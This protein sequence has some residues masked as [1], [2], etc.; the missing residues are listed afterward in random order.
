MSSYKCLVSI[1][2]IAY[3]HDKYISQALEGF[4][5]QKTNFAFEVIV[6]DDAS[7]DETVDIIRGYVDKYPDIIKP[8]FQTENQYSKGIKVSS[9]YVWP[10]ARGRYIALCEG[11][12]YWTDLYKLQKQVDFLEANEDFALCFHKVKVLMQ[13]GS[14]VD[15]FITKVPR[16]VTT[17][18]DLAKRGNYIHTPSVVLRNDFTIP[19]WFLNCPIGDYPLYLIAA[20]QG[21]IKYL[22]DTMAVYRNGVGIHS[23]ASS[24]GRAINLFKTYDAIICNYSDKQISK[25]ISN[26][27][28]RI[29]FSL[30]SK[31]LYDQKITVDQKN[32]FIQCYYRASNNPFYSFAID[33][34]KHFL[35]F[36]CC[37]MKWMILKIIKLVKSN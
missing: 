33:L 13:D 23:G 32:L 30:L 7:T 24:I 35:L 6:H 3:N 8:I 4:V 22:E 21:K 9:T 17:V 20:R 5:A 1:C 16:H 10:R 29:Y 2:C 34:I 28:K 15:D 36:I 25:I 18:K 31:Y 26:K 12:D 27:K 19:D 11:D 37:R 14:L